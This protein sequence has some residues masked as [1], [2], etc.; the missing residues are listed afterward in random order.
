MRL[1]G[2]HLTYCLNVHPGE[3]LADT[4]AVLSGPTADIKRLV[5]P[6]HAFGVGLR[7]ANQASLELELPSAR[8]ELKRRLDEAE[9]YAFTING[10]PY[11][12]FHG[13]AVKQSVYE[14][15]WASAERADYTLRLARILAALLP[16][17]VSG[18][19]STVP[20]G[21]GRPP[22]S[23]DSLATMADNL[24]HVVVG[25]WQLEQAT[26]QRISLA[27]EPEPDCVLQTTEDVVAVFHRHFYASPFLHHLATECGVGTDAAR[28]VCARYLGV[29]VDTC[30][31]AVE[32]ESAASVFDAL[33]QN[34]ITVGKVQ[35]SAGLR[36]APGDRSARAALSRFD[37][38]VYLHQA[39][40]R[41]RDGQLA[42]YADLGVALATEP[43][44]DSEW[45]VHFHVPLHVSNYKALTS[46]RSFVEEVLA[47][48]RR[49]PLSSH[50]EVETYTWDV[51]P[52]RP[53][54]IVESI[55]GELTWV[56][57][58]L[59]TGGSR[60]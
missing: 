17:D 2:S 26:G 24:R 16:P 4:F 30:H 8:E 20:L 22:K 40:V 53:A 46:T 9:M 51:L 33:R 19:I 15:D 32:F 13:R 45:R 48:H 12:A 42:R 28:D 14:P 29:C 37:E 6:D 18:T 41:R 35:L 25:L 39:V 60:E 43:S 21:Y 10:F 57:S 47:L 5:C 58:Q 55:A 23:P 56:R 11:G 31:A 34:G 27:L 49:T 44:N 38:P 7:I 1:G 50:L 59:G 3:S 54:S 52:E 36:A